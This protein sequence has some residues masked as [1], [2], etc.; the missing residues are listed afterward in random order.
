MISITGRYLYQNTVSE[1]GEKGLMLLRTATEFINKDKLLEICELQDKSNEDYL[2][3]V[4]EFTNIAH[5]NNLLYLY[6]VYYDEQGTMRYGVVADGLDDTLGLALNEEDITSEVILAM[7]NGEE[8]YTQPYESSEWGRLMSCSIPIKDAQ[9]N[10]IGALSA[11]F[12]QDSVEKRAQNILIKLGMIM[13]LCTVVVGMIIYL[14]IKKFITKPIE[15]L[16]LSLETISNGDFTQEISLAMQRKKDEIGSIARTLEK[17]RKFIFNLVNN[18]ISE[19]QVIDGA[20]E[21]NCA[22]IAGLNEK[23]NHIV[24]VSS[25]VSAAMEETAASTQE[26]E[27]SA[28]HI[29]EVL[30]G[31]NKEAGNG[32]DEVSRINEDVY[33]SNTNIEKS[34]EHADMISKDIQQ[35]LESSMKKAE[36]IKV[37]HQSVEII[38]SI[39]EQTN[40]LALNASIEAARAGESGKGFA[41]VAEEVRKLAE[42]S[43]SATEVIREKV[44]LAIESVQELIDNSKQALEFLNQ[45]VMND[46]NQFLVSGTNYVEKSNEMK[47]L[48]DE[49]AV[50]TNK[51]DQSVQ[52]MNQ[53]IQEVASATQATTQETVSIFDN[54]NQINKMV[55]EISTET[56]EI[57]KRMHN[58][59]MITNM[60]EN[61]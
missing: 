31:I 36:D 16:E 28:N 44:V 40:L 34:K 35:K 19:T 54:V 17:T 20:V 8:R 49:F 56:Q 38:M 50:T 58:L 47:V 15:Q 6:S 21:R 33:T 2:N 46:Y 7:Q 41:V 43:K 37:I 5:N 14:L 45:K 59:L 11:D 60:Q 18:I 48:F 29:S 42:E 57:K 1:S 26:M 24:D 23:I 4:Q 39:S 52:K 32:V 51:L 30:N 3:M 55:E 13:L 25:N 53:S 9:G 27:S 10:I 22:S 61:R 12:S